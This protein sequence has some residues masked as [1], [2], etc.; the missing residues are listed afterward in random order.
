[1][2]VD[3]WS[4]EFHKLYGRCC[5]DELEGLRVYRYLRGLKRNIRVDV[6]DLHSVD[7]AASVG[8]KDDKYGPNDEVVYP[9]EGDTASEGEEEEEHMVN[10][11]S[12]PS[13]DPPVDGIHDV[14][15]Q[16]KINALLVE[17]RL[18]PLVILL[19]PRSQDDIVPRLSAASLARLRNEIIQTDWISVLEKEDWKS[20]VEFLNN[21]KQVVT[22][23]QDVARKVAEY[24]KF[25]NGT[26][27]S[28]VSSANK[29]IG[30]PESL[31]I[32]KR[33]TVIMNEEKPASFTHEELFV[34]GTV[35]Y[36]KRNTETQK[37]GSNKGSKNI[38]YYTLWKRDFEQHF[39]RIL[40]SSNLISAHKCDS[41]YYALRDVLKGLPASSS[42]GIF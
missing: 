19:Q 6:E 4:R 1:M 14:I 7:H 40:L 25:R 32:S 42:E 10:V 18:G 15:Y 13:I 16:S 34:P 38:E 17:H 41:H 5:L 33:T 39:Q 3:A 8:R 37:D 35:Y 23:V 29:T 27:P 26:N 30:G 24:A 36:L 9:V 21:A 11:L 31:P 22:S 12:G 28:D 20:V 2:S